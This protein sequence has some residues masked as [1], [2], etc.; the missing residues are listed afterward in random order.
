MTPVALALVAASVVLHALWHFISKKNDPHLSFFLPI[1]LTVLVMGLPMLVFAGAWP[2][3][4]PP[5]IL[6]CAL[7]G[8][9]CGM[10]CDLGLSYAYRFSEISLAYPMARALPVLLTAFVTWMCGIGRP[11]S[12]AALAGMGVIF[13]GCILLP[14]A[15]RGRIRFRMYWNKGMIGIFAAAV[16]TTGYTV[17]DGMGVQ[18]IFAY[19]PDAGSIL[20]AGAYSCLREAVLFSTLFLCSFAVER[21]SSFRES[22]RNRDAYLAGISACLAYLLILIAMNHVTNVSFVQAFRQLSLPIGVLMGAVLLRERIGLAKAF[23]L[24]LILGG[25]L[26]VYLG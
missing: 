3:H 7:G 11:L 2:W 21:R 19:L 10:L 1:S 14:L 4:L 6:W 15:G 23:A 18:A 5:K 9:I 17:V 13:A 25:L 20:P 24:T 12:A 26:A 8:G 22:F 16:G